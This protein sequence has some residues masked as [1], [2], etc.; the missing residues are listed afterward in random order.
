MKLFRQDGR[1][2]AGHRERGSLS[3]SHLGPRAR[4]NT[5]PADG[6]GTKADLLNVPLQLAFRSGVEEHR[7]GG[8]PDRRYEGKCF[9]TCRVPFFREEEREVHNPRGAGLPLF[10]L[11]LPSFLV[12]IRRHPQPRLLAPSRV[13]RFV[14]SQDLR[15]CFEVAKVYE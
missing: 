8:G 5:W 6:E 4:D 3:V 11:W 7:G 15:V 12:H 13:P 1:E 14:R 10:L 2:E 9:Y